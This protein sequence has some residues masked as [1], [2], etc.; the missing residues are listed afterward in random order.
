MQA[1]DFMGVMK[2]F[3]KAERLVQYEYFLPIHGPLV[4]IYNQ[5]ENKVPPQLL[6]PMAAAYGELMP[7]YKSV[8]Y[9][10]LGLLYVK[11]GMFPEAKSALLSAMELPSTSSIAHPEWP[12]A[13]LGLLA[14]KTGDYASAEKYFKKSLEIRPGSTQGACSLVHV[15]A[16]TRRWEAAAEAARDFAGATQVQDTNITRMN[17]RSISE[18][19]NA[20]A[21]EPGGKAA[22]AAPPDIFRC[23]QP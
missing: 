12:S 1:G 5:I 8:L 14:F 15:Y 4:A 17:R 16:L 21:R 10:V 3:T 18:L 6:A 9:S 20:V 13:G 23:F 22:P 11:H 7:E 2:S 19:L